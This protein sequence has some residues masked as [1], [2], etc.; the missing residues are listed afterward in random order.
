MKDYPSIPHSK[1]QS[2]REIAN[3]HIQDKLD[4][5]S[6]RSQWSRKRG[7]YKHGKRSGLIDDSNPHLVVVPELFEKTLA[8][9][10]TKLAVDNKWEDLIVFYEFWGNRSLAGLHFEND[11][12]FLTVFDAAIDKKGI[13][14]PARFRKLFADNVPTP[15]L[16]DICHWTRGYMDLV[17]E[18]KISGITF[19]GVVAKAGEGHDI[20]RAKAKTQAWIN[21]VMEVHGEI[22]KRLVDS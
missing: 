1:G 21:R 9:P 3:A 19:E 2:F 8:E 14:G 4:G 11:P 16:L 22:G 12:K 10:L 6:M 17:R 15:R 20:V 7:W 18:G 13:T 5:S